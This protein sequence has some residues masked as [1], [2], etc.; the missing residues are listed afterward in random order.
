MGREGELE[1]FG[2]SIRREEG[3]A[4]EL[5]WKEGLLFGS[6]DAFM[7]YFTG[8]FVITELEYEFEPT[9]LVSLTWRHNWRLPSSNTALS[10]PPISYPHF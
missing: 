4:R 9:I 8:L 2:L 3:N 7:F 6:C 10:L 1:A 5:L